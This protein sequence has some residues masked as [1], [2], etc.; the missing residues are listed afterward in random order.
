M[1]RLFG[2]GPF[3]G[4]RGA[5]GM[6]SAGYPSFAAYPPHEAGRALFLFINANLPGNGNQGTAH[7]DKVPY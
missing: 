1:A 2:N 7:N 3:C 6:R 5:L 4:C